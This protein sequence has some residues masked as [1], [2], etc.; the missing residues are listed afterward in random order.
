MNDL[1]WQLANA[2]KN[3]SSVKEKAVP[4]AS[5]MAINRV[6]ARAVSRSVKSTAQA[7]KV[8]Q[9]VIRPRAKVRKASVKMPVA[10]IKV[11]R[12]DIPAISI[13]TAR[14]QIKRQRGKYLVGRVR[15]GTDGRY[16]ARDVA[17][18]TS[19]RVGRHKF[20]NAF[21]QKLKNGR[22]HIMQRTSDRRYPIQVCK[23]PVVNEITQAFKTHSH[24][25]MKSD[26]PREL[27]AALRH[28]LRLVLSKD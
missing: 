27:Q 21:L 16:Q 3:L 15:R 7:V 24:Q 20:E 10:Y 28:Q 13:G 14:T 6:A 26:M 19:I 5:A 2:V 22:W 1:D 4:K 17:G 23:V 12:Y 8:P 9:K 25:L 18:E 11:R